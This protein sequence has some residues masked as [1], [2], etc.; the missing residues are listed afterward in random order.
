MLSGSFSALDWEYFTVG[1]D[2]FLVVANSYDG[3]SYSL[4]SVIYR[5]GS[6]IALGLL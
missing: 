1:E 2:K 4:N 6:H 3:N 5:Y